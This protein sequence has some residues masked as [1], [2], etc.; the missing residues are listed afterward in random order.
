MGF[1]VR[2]DDS[3]GGG[4]KWIQGMK[5][6]KGALHKQMGIPQGEKI[7]VSKLKAAAAKGGTLGKRANLA[8]TFSK[9]KKG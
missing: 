1:T 4:K 8:L 3:G 9:M 6:K 5:M 7:P 2:E